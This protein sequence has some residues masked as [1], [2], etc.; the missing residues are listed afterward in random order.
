MHPSR[1]DTMDGR[2]RRLKQSWWKPVIT[3][4]ADIPLRR[5]SSYG[6]SDICRVERL[7]LLSF[8][9]APLRYFVSFMTGDVSHDL[10]AFPIDHL[11]SH[12]H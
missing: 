1:G 7:E 5:A 12:D 6:L 8:G 11:P 3:A 2:P 9:I 4:A 10:A